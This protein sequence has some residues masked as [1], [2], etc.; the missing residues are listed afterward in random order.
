MLL[1]RIL[2]SP[3]LMPSLR[4][5]ACL[6][7]AYLR[8]CESSFSL[9]C[10]AGCWRTIR[11]ESPR[12]APS[13]VANLANVYVFFYVKSA[14]LFDLNQELYYFCN[15]KTKLIFKNKDHNYIKTQNC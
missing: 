1:L 4:S 2:A 13:S 7:F 5:M 11:T 12:K 8:P 6:L 10:T 15:R 14:D 9:K 3:I